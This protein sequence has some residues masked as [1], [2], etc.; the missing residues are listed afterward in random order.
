MFLS[1]SNLLL[2]ILY[3]QFLVQPPPKKKRHNSVVVDTIIFKLNAKLHEVMVKFVTDSYDISLCAIKGIT[4]EIT[5]KK[6][7]TQIRAKLLDLIVSDLNP[8]SVHK[9]VS[10]A[11]F[12]F[13]VIYTKRILDTNGV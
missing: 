11:T 6:P 1:Y 10:N 4:S 2:I 7:Y 13:I 3:F 5:V 12:S 8:K 9:Q